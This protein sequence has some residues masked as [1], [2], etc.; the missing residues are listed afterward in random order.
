VLYLA[1]DESVFMNATKLVIDGRQTASTT[2][3]VWE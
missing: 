3:K 2:G 1:S